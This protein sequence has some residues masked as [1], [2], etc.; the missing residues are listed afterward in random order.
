MASVDHRIV[1]MEFNN[2]AFEEGI[3]QSTQS[4]RAL[5]EGIN[6]SSSTRGLAGIADSVEDISSRATSINPLV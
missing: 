6:A 1:N 4:L 3:Q 5:N 2:K